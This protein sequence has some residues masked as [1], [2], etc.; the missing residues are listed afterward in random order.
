LA[1]V[2]VGGLLYVWV[3][4]RIEAVIRGGIVPESDSLAYQNQ[5][6]WELTL[7]QRGRL[8]LADWFLGAGGTNVTA[9]LHRWSLE[10][11]YLVFGLDNHIPYLVSG[12]WVLL[13]ATA[14][15]LATRQL[16]DD[17]RLSAGAAVVLLGLPAARV[18][19]FMETRNDWP[20]TA[21]VVLFYYSVLKSE[22]FR[23]RRSSIMVGACSGLGLLAKSSIAGYLALPGLF[24]LVRGA[25]GRPRFDRNQWTNLGLAAGITLVVAGWFY[26]SRW[27][28]ILHYY[29]F[30]THENLANVLVQ[31]QLS[32]RADELLFYPRNFVRQTSGAVATAA[33]LGLAGLLLSVATRR[34]MAG[35]WQPW[36]LAWAACFVAGPYAVLIWRRS[37]AAIADINML[38]FMLILAVVGVWTWLRQWLGPR[39]VGPA[40]VVL[41]LILCL[42]SLGRHLQARLY[43]GV[44][45]ENGAK[46]V[47]Q[48]LHQAGLD[49][50]SAWGLYQD[51]R[52]NTATILN[53]LYRDSIAR[54]RLNGR[55][56]D[57]TLEEM[58][59]G[60]AADTRYRAIAK[61]ADV[62]FLADRPKGPT[63]VTI[64]REWAEHRGLVAKDPR[65]VLLGQVEPYDDGTNVDVW[66]KTLA[67]LDTT[68]DGWVENNARLIVL[69]R[70]GRVELAIA[71]TAHDLG[72]T[73]L[74]LVDQANGVWPG[75]PCPVLE[76]RRFRFV[77]ETA[78]PKSV[79]HL[80]SASPTVPAALG[81]SA[82]QRELL[83]YRPSTRIGPDP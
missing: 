24:L 37:Y 19:G 83:L 63:W 60:M 68:A 62:L 82:D 53:V 14:V 16:T 45:Q 29:T 49:R 79:F 2:L 9:P 43:A 57:L 54:S 52:F 75:Q 65:F 55:A 7:F 23:L 46:A 47:C 70:P 36:A 35:G 67:R 80:L 22:F 21:L 44:D 72:A 28:G 4:Y 15:Y 20:V 61:A 32:N 17:S 81:V 13:A 33:V 8:P 51:T 38:P 76:G 56:A 25:L 1:A 10:L 3:H 48:L 71:G 27:Q 18:W 39:T 34:R 66:A 78:Q 50:F 58:V 41:G 30:W 73:D 69:A 31:Y 6:L 59:G 11:M 40:L 42:F 5:A 26:L 77:V 64:N 12:L 74:Y